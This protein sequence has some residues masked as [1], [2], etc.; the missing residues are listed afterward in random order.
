MMIAH[1]MIEWLSVDGLYRIPRGLHTGVGL[2]TIMHYAGVV[3]HHRWLYATPDG[4]LGWFWLRRTGPTGGIIGG[5]AD[6]TDVRP[7]G[8]ALERKVSFNCGNRQVVC[9]APRV[10][11]DRLVTFLD[12]P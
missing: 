4:Q 12:R 3:R 9:Y 1:F 11:A 6:I 7:S 10:E 2:H 5:L 8:L